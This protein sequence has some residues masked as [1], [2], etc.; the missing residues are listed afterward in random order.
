MSATAAHAGTLSAIAFNLPSSLIAMIN[1][2]VTD[3]TP[4]QSR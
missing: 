2:P 4:A 1:L 3:Y